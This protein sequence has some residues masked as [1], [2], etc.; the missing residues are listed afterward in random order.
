MVNIA[1]FIEAV[2]HGEA[3]VGWA[4]F[5]NLALAA[6]ADLDEFALTVAP[7]Q[8]VNDT[9]A[10]HGLFFGEGECH[11]SG[12]GKWGVERGGLAP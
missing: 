5:P 12:S 7:S 2:L 9:R 10:R 6:G 4:G 1:R 3:E 8:V 11:W